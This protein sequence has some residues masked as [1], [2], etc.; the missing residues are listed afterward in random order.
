MTTVVN[1]LRHLASS[2][3]IRRTIVS[4]IAVCPML[5]ACV[6]RQATQVQRPIINNGGCSSYI[7]AV[8][9][10]ASWQSNGVDPL[11]SHR[12]R[13]HHRKHVTRRCRQVHIHLGIQVEAIAYHACLFSARAERS[14]ATKQPEGL[15]IKMAGLRTP[16]VPTP[17]TIP[18]NLVKRLIDSNADLLGNRH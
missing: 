11:T 18:R 9:L 5:Y 3:S 6:V 1:A 2:S 14:N 17:F 12:R 13:D 10:A 8:P 7:V 16:V 15:K 4:K